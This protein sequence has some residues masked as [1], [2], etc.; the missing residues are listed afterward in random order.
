M[1]NPRDRRALVLGAAAVV[2]ALVLLRVGPWSWRSVRD[3]RAELEA[4]AELLARM[5]SDVGLASRLEDSGKVVRS[6]MALLAP[7]LLSGGTP[8]EAVAD[9]GARLGVVAE[10]HHVRLSRTEPSLDSVGGGGLGR[11]TLK[12]A[13]D[14]DTGGLLALLES[15]AREPAALVVEDLR[16][17][18]A[19]P[20]IGR[21]RPELL[22]AELT[23]GGWYLPGRRP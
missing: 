19:D 3:A 13:L 1:V 21:N 15:L 5:E 12:A 14:S 2:L 10:H 20:F 11:V 9:L 7:K 4:R 17:A 8:A 6:R 16:V 23:V 18:V 22:H